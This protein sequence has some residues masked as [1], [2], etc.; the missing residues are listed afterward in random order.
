MTLRW[1]LAGTGNIARTFATAVAASSTSE[2][3]AVASRSADRAAA[4]AGTP[5]GGLAL[6]FFQPPL[7]L[8]RPIEI[9][10]V[11]AHRLRQ[12]CFQLRDPDP[13][14]TQFQHQG[15]GLFQKISIAL[16]QAWHGDDRGTQRLTS[17]I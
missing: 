14:A 4:F 11:V 2:L 10:K 1:G 8:T 16:R 7:G 13:R 6:E 17:S 5:E 15:F 3:T 9:R 12:A